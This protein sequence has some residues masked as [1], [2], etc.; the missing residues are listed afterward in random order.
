M[1]QGAHRQA[2]QRQ[3]KTVPYQVQNDEAAA[4]AADIADQL[5]IIRL[6]QVVRHA[7]GHGDIGIRQRRPDRVGLHDRDRR[8]IGRRRPQLDADHV[9]AQLLADL[10]QQPSRATPDIEHAVDRQRVA[11]QSGDD[12]RRIAQPAMRAGQIA[13]HCAHE[14]V[15][16]IGVVDN[17]GGERALEHAFFGSILPASRYRFRI[18]VI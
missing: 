10:Q 8:Q 18:S 2:K 3:W 4:I 6:A 1:N 9:G 16:Q 13:M 14:V 12:G 15:G 5:D 11:L 7:H 17:L